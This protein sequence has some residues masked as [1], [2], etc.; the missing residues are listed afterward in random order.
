MDESYDLVIPDDG[1]PALIIANTFFGALHGM[2]SF[3]QLV[4]FNS[5]SESYELKG[6]PWR[7]HDVPAYPVAMHSRSH[8]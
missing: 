7:I 6:A 3:S 1:S 2:E 8:L 5:A 4:Y